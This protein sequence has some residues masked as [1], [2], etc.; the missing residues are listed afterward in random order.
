LIKKV[1]IL[2]ILSGA[3]RAQVLI[4]TS[5]TA[6]EN[7]HNFNPA[8]IK[9]KGIKKITFEIVDKKDFEVAVDKGLTEMYEFNA[10]GQLSRYF[11]TN[12][13]KTLEHHTT[14]VGRKG[15][16]YTQVVTDY[17][18]DTVSTT[19][20]Y[21]NGKPILKRYHDG[22]SYYE[23][24][25]YNYDSAGCLTRELRYRETN[26]GAD[27]SVF[28]LG[29]QVLLS[30]DSFQYVRYPSGQVKCIFLNNENRP[31]KERITNYDSLGRVKSQSEDYTA[32]AWINQEQTF[33]YLG[34]RLV[35]ARFQGNANSKIDLVNVYEYDEK[36]E[37][38][39]EKQYKNN[40]LVKEVSYV[41]DR[42]TLLLNSLIIR[43]PVNKTMRI[44]KLKYDFGMIGKTGMLDSTRN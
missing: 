33:E 16:K 39:S 28:M 38:Y 22:Q 10:D 3:V 4:P 12:I 34:N 25:Y 6:F 44:V 7:Q 32:A 30:A 8:I 15:R 36:N 31:Y 27:K 41:T 43:D 29:N 9:T 13:V 1:F 2:I 24:R 18:Y 5:E 20:F 42:S 17:V 37:L 21:N 23:S 11:Y 35:K 40:V 14:V 26:N 19:Y